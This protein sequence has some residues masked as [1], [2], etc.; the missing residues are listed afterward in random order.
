MNARTVP[1]ARIPDHPVPTV[2]QRWSQVSAPRSR[3]VFTH[4]GHDE[5]ARLRGR[6]AFEMWQAL[7][8]AVDIGDTLTLRPPAEVLLAVPHSADLLDLLEKVTDRLDVIIAVDVAFPLGHPEEIIGS[9]EAVAFWSDPQHE[10]HAFRAVEL[11]DV[12]TT[13]WPMWRGVPGWLDEIG[14]HNPNVVVLP[15]LTG[16]EDDTI[17]FA[18]GL[19]AAWRVGWAAKQARKAGRR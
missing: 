15:D 10:A 4:Y 16:G 12:V 6:A 5:H 13:P 18:N 2:A 7:G 14:A 1:R 19:L 3:R 11:A 9:E 17:R 8:Q